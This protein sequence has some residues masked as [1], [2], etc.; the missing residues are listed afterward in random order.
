M[1]MESLRQSIS[2]VSVRKPVIDVREAWREFEASRHQLTSLDGLQVRSLCTNEETALHPKFIA[3]LS[4]N[5]D[6]LR[7]SL[8]LYGI[9]SAYFSCWRAMES[10]E[11]VETV[12]LRAIERLNQSNPVIKGWK[13]KPDLFSAKAADSLADAIVRSQSSVGKT[14]QNAFVGLGS[15][16]AVFTRAAVSA[17]ATKHFERQELV[18]NETSNLSYL[19]WMI[20]EVLPAPLPNDAHS[21]SAASLILSKSAERSAVFQTKLLEYVRNDKRLGDPR[22]A[23]NRPHWIQVA[24]QAERR[25]LSWLA[26]DSILFF[27][28]TI[29]PDTSDNR[30]RKEFWLRYTNHIRDFQVAVSEQ[31]SWRLRTIQDKK[32]RTFS[33]VSHSTASAFLMRFEGYSGDFVVVEFSETGNAARI[34]SQKAF[35]GT[36][37]N[38]RTPQ[39][40]LKWHLKH[41]NH[42]HRIL[43]NGEWWHEAAMRLAELGIRP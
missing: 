41:E 35:E 4:N 11:K 18:G 33:R 10:P 40:H 16:L 6:V 38:F 43:H 2:E 15:Q 22:I 25:F 42:I 13:A 27:F 23:V 5:P 24:S 29:L 34:Y 32:L 17:Q 9:V 37:V 28:N 26:R 12:I 36:N 39:F 7:R 31:D 14:L 20:R 3:A 30:L 19:D 1:A 21:M 8:C